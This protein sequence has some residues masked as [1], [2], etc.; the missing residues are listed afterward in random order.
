[1]TGEAV[2]V[3]RGVMKDTDN[4]ASSRVTAAR[5]ILETV[6]KTVETEDLE[7]R[8]AKIERE[9]QNRDKRGEA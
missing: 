2:D 8:L 1:V 6:L 4:P 3:L 7:G 9:I 5:I